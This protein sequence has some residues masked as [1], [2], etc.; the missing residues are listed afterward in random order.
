MRMQDDSDINHVMEIKTSLNFRVSNAAFKR[1]TVA[2]NLSTA[3][4]TRV[5]L[6][7]E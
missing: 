3:I 1:N 7:T 5:I 2:M 4:N 6:D